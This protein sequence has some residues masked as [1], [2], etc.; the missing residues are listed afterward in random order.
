MKFKFNFKTVILTALTLASV[1]FAPQSFADDKRAS[2]VKWASSFVPRDT[3]PGTVTIT[4]SRT[5]FSDEICV[6][7][8][9]ASSQS[10]VN[11]Y[12][13]SVETTDEALNQKL[14][15][16]WT[17]GKELSEDQLRAK[18]RAVYTPLIQRTL[19]QY[20]SSYYTG[21]KAKKPFVV[22]ADLEVQNELVEPDFSGKQTDVVVSSNFSVLESTFKGIRD[23]VTVETQSYNLTY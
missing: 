13:S 4:G 20:S 7:P 1:V 23:K 22:Q 18:I 2:K 11:V 3:A 10:C 16:Y 6:T 19:N 21:Y 14:L 5:L 12:V 15:D 8:I 17:G 9:Y